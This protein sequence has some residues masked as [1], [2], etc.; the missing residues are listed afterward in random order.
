[1]LT[2]LSRFDAIVVGGSVAGLSFA[3]EAERRGLNVLVLEEHDEIGRPEKCDGLVSLRGLRR[4]GFAPSGGVIQSSVRDCVIHSPTGPHLAVDARSLEVVV[5]DRRR[6]D[7]EL[8][9]KASRGG[10]KVKTGVR[11]QGTVGREDGVRVKADQV[12]DCDYLVDASGPAS[13]PVRGIIPA[14]KYE[15]E[16]DWVEEGRV[17]VFIDQDKYPGFFAWVIPYGERRAKV[18]AAGR[19]INPFKA[20]D[21]F[22]EGRPCT[23]TRRVA[24]PIYVGGP[25]KKFVSGRFLSV[26]EAAGQVKPTT[27][28]GIATSIAGG[29]IA[30]KWVA[31]S[32][33]SGNPALL[34]RYEADWRGVF[35]KE[36]RVMMRLRGAYEALSNEEVDLVM[37]T[38]FSSPRLIGRLERSDFDFHATALMSALGVVG[39]FRMTRLIASVEARRL[40][41]RP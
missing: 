24:A 18:G 29:A 2:G 6:Y 19:G 8:A 11:V 10:A 23:V 13:A 31:E 30:A 32:T 3:S 12:Y 33:V 16:A 1:M 22:L 5:I 25:A 40:L 20:L 35:M 41:S 26:G 21:A 38:I 4:Y 28:G 9:E 15:I 34:E 27:A 14:A 36:M 17:E 37:T 39:L 7:E